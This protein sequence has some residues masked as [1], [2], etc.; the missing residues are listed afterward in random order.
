LR[1]TD[2]RSIVVVEQ[3]GDGSPPAVH[4]LVRGVP[5]GVNTG[6]ALARSGWRTTGLPIRRSWGEVVGVIAA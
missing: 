1:I 5:A 4:Q 3:F 6:A 2:W